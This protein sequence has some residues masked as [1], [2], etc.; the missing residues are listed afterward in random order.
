MET[1][2]GQQRRRD[3]LPSSGLEI[4]LGYWLRQ[5][6]NHVSGAYARALHTRE[7]S[8]AEWVVLSH[9]QAR[10]GV[11]PSDLAEALGLTRGAISKVLDKL[12]RKGW[13]S[14]ATHARDNR[15]QMVSLTRPGRRI[16]PRLAEIADRNDAQFFDCLDDGERDD[17]RRLL[18]KLAEFH[19]IRDVPVE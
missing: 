9:V 7:T 2:L 5:V 13:I 12:E 18:R 19:H 8:V 4:H 10:N 6:S 17:L 16:L 15:V 3:S 14:R 1:A 11:S